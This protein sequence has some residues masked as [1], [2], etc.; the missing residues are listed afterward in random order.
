MA[1]SDALREKL[2]EVALAMAEQLAL[3]NAPEDSTVDAFKAL[4]VYCIGIKRVT[5]KGE[6]DQPQVGFG[7]FKASIKEAET[8][9]DAE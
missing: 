7:G 3:G 6:D 1:K 9:E 2:D 8:V 5:K 4:S